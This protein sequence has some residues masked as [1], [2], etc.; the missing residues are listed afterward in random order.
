MKKLF[1]KKNLKYL[2]NAL[3]VLAG[4]FLMGFAFNVFLDANHISPSGFAG[5]CSIISNVIA[6]HLNFRIPASILYLAINGVLF[7]FSLKKMGINFA[8]NSAIGILGYSLFIELCKFDIGLGSNDLLLCAIYGGVVMGIGLGLV[9]RGH[10]S[11]GGSD[12]LANILGK[13]F[14]FL[15]VGNLVLIVDT[16]VVVLSFVAYGN[17][18]LSLY[19]LIS[20]YIM[21]KISDIIVDG[22]QG[23]RAYYIISNNYEQISKEI[24]QTLERGVTGFEAQGMY[25]NNEQKVLMTVVTRS[26]SVKLRQIVASIDKNAFVYSTPIS[27][28]MG[29]GFLPLTNDNQKI[30][31]K[32]NKK[33]QNEIIVKTENNENQDDIETQTINV[34]NSQDEVENSGANTTNNN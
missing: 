3:L 6:E 26:E 12:M 27:E 25:T 23:V 2:F 32:K 1:S 29:Y 33:E 11:T 4:T 17:L 5:L 30:Q 14:K 10:G 31:N 24:M 9:F 16:I 13:R 22:V 21:T 8:I 18:N 34:A 19:S 20:I 28:A 7:F 15:T